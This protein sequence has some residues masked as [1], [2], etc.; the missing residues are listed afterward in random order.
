MSGLTIFDIFERI[1]IVITPIVV[2]LVGLQST[3]IQKRSEDLVASQNAANEA[4][5]KL[6]DNEKKQ[7]DAEMERH[8]AKVEE[9]ITSLTEKVDKL[10]KTVGNLSKL[11]Q[12]LSGLVELSTANLELCQS[13]SN[14]V[15]SIGDALDSS[16]AIE[17][18]D[19]RDQINAHRKKE[20][21]L[22]LRVAKI[23]Y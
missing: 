14:I 3:K 22:T 6:A 7:R 23:I 16:E 2:A 21:E 9:S 5:K 1:I 4:A 12:Q 17:S 11:D 8:F 18:G 13:L 10:D 19:L 20:Q 15:S